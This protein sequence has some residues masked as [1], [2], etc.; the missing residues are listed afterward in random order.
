[1]ISLPRTTPRLLASNIALFPRESSAGTAYH[2]PMSRFGTDY[3]V[4]RSTGRC[5]ATGE[6]LQPGSPCIATLC[7]KTAMEEEG[8]E[9]RDFSMQAW[10]SGAR[11]E[12]L[13]SH[14]KTIVP[15]PD[16]KPRLLLDDNVLLDLFERLGADDRPQR[17]AFRFV[18][19]LIL[20]RKKHL[21]FIGR[22]VDHGVERWLLQPRAPAPGAEPP[23]TLA[24]INP[25]LA[26]DDVRGIIE[27]LGEILQ[28]EL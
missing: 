8:F 25:D 10:E 17:I 1:M 6:M 9:R 13:F 23:P 22:Q 11:P 5:S 12:G 20:M 19:G 2:A 27:Q 4:A 15:H 3:Q 18:I 21:K 26:D 16:D 7:E 14:W 24:V 28:A